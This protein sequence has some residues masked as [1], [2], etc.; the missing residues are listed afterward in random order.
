MKC[1]QCGKEILR[2]GAIFNSFCST[3]YVSPG[4]DT[5]LQKLCRLAHT[6]GRH[7]HDKHL[8][9]GYCLLQIRGNL[10]RFRN[11]NSGKL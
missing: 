6:P 10:H 1:R 2:K 11:F 4:S 7:H 3:D 5:L 9:P 8:F